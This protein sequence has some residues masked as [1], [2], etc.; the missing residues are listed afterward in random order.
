MDRIKKQI[1]Q[2]LEKRPLSIYELIDWQDASLKE[3]VETVEELK[4]EGIVKI[5]NGK[6]GLTEKGK[7]FVK[8]ERLVKVYSKCK[9]CNG[10]GYKISEFFSD[11]F[12]EYSEIARDRPESIEKY[13][14]GFISLDGV[15]RRIEFLHERGDLIADI[16]VVG[17]DDLFSIAAALTGLPKKIVVIDIDERLIDFINRIADKY[18][19]P[20]H[21]FVYDVQNEFPKEYEKRFD[22]F[23]TDPVETLPG[24]KLFLSRG[25]SSLKGEGCSGYFGLTTLEAS[26]KKWYEI[27]KMIHQM[28]FVITDIRRKFNVYPEEEKNFFRF[29]HKF[30][31]VKKIGRKIDY[32]WYTSCLYRIEAIKEPIPLV[33]GKMVIDEKIYKDDES[34]ATPY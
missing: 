26:R 4:A 7:E 32:N 28:G 9:S 1:L 22:V 8:I 5:E 14:Q 16:F 29:Q 25:V 11:A 3:F 18:D 17:D 34:W 30:P 2:A 13:D 21:A 31:I 33:T 19:L 24:I 20:I 23:L 10:T 15:I 12:K 27:Q 6:V